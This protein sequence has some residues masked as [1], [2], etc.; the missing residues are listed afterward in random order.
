[1]QYKISSR[2]SGIQ[3]SAIREILK[4][5][6]GR[7]VIPFAAGNPSPDCFPVR[8]IANITQ[9][10]LN[11]SPVT[12]LQY[13]VSEGYGPLRAAVRR[14]LETREPGL[15]RE[16]DEIL[17]TTGAQQGIEL[18]AKC[19]LNEG[20]EML[21]EE[22][23]FIG[24]LNA[25][26]SYGARLIGVPL[27]ADGIDLDQLELALKCHP[28]AKLLYVIPNFQNPAGCTLAL[29][30]R[31]ALLLLAQKYDIL[32]LEDNPYGELAFGAPK[33]PTLKSM[34]TEGRVLYV[35]S[36]SKIVSPGMRVGYVVCDKALMGPVVVAK[37]CSDVHT[38]AL[39][40]MICERFL[41]TANLAN[42]IAGM[43]KIYRAKRDVMAEALDTQMRGKVRYV[44]PEGGLFVWCELPEGSDMIAYCAEASARGVAVVPGSAFM[45]DQQAPCRSFRITFSQPTA[46]QIVR[47][48]D[49]LSQIPLQK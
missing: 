9:L 16:E 39:T 23:S 30:K 27:Q 4:G 21:C 5:A 48:I 28:K 32:V 24:A 26:R 42:H 29:E 25:F 22:P 34:D 38:P 13:S 36:F 43:C 37:Q 40:Q 45:V 7:D 35:G 18:L 17:I 14:M 20:D 6:T 10:I 15:V 41:S 12:A 8:E 11:D 19:L 49:I 47:G 46:E 2:M 3:P 44:K 1:M 31:R 33:L